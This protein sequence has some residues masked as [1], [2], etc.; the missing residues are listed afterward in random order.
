MDVNG[1]GKVDFEE[2]A[3]WWNLNSA[4][5]VKLKKAIHRQDD[6]MR[7]VWMKIDTDHDN[8]LEE[9]E[10]KNMAGLLDIQLSDKEIEVAMWEMS[11]ETG[12]VSFEVF[13]NW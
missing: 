5:V 12:K 6:E 13:T 4:F 10:I 2:F 7:S 9:D 1:D 3:Q 11:A 8:S